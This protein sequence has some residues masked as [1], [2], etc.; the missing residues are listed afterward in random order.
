MPFKSSAVFL[1]WLVWSSHGQRGSYMALAMEQ[2]ISKLANWFFEAK[3]FFFGIL[4]SEWGRGRMDKFFFHFLAPWIPDAPR[5]GR[6]DGEHTEWGRVPAAVVF[7][8]NCFHWAMARLK[9]SLKEVSRLNATVSIHNLVDPASSSSLKEL[10]FH[11]VNIIQCFRI[12]LKEIHES[13]NGYTERTWIFSLDC[14]YSE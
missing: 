5:L 7:Q 12:F 1:C 3:M 11:S 2:S 8:R 4:V 13:L 9:P 10:E 14:E 6:C